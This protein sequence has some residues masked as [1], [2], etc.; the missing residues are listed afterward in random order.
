M[1]AKKPNTS[2]HIWMGRKAAEIVSG[3]LVEMRAGETF[4]SPTPSSTRSSK[5]SQFQKVSDPHWIPM[6]SITQG[7]PEAPAAPPPPEKPP[8]L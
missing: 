1:G 2:Q 3:I 5:L 4:V 7:A 6:V 8:S